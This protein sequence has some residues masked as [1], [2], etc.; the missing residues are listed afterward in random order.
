MVNFEKIKQ[1][2]NKIYPNG[3]DSWCYA[4]LGK[5]IVAITQCPVAFFNAGASGSD[6]ENWTESIPQNSATQGLTHFRFA[7]RK[8]ENGNNVGC[9]YNPSNPTYCDAD[10]FGKFP[11]TPYVPLRN[12]LQTFCSMMGIRA[13]LWHQGETDSER[14]GGSDFV[15]Y[16]TNFNILKNRVQTDFRDENNNPQ[17]GLSWFVSKVSW[18]RSFPDDDDKPIPIWSDQINSNLI[19]QQSILGNNNSIGANTDNI[20][21]Q[22][23]PNNPTDSTRARKRNGFNV[24]FSNYGLRMLAD[25]WL[26]AQPWTGNPISGKPLLPITITAS[27]VNAGNYNLSAPTGYAEYIWV[28]DGK[29]F[30][31]YIAKG[32]TLSDV[33][34]FSNQ[35]IMCYVSKY[36]DLNEQNFFACQPVAIG[37]ETP[38]FYPDFLTFDS[39]ENDFLFTPSPID[40]KAYN[41]INA[42]NAVKNNGTPPDGTKVNYQAGKAIILEN[43]FNVQSGTTFKAEI[44]TFEDSPQTWFSDNIGNGS[45]SSNVTNNVLSINGTGSLGGTSD[46]IHFY[47]SVYSGDVTITARIDAM[48]TSNG[49]RAGIMIRNTNDSDSGFYELIIDGNGNVGKL[50]RKNA[51]ETADIWG[52]AQCPT[53]G[54]WIK[55]EKAGNTITCFFR[56]TDSFNWLE[57]V[58]WDEHSDNN[59]SANF[60]IGFVAYS[61]ASATFSNISISGAVVN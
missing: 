14:H 12:T 19:N 45:G 58:G 26:D 39:P 53:S 46:D 50:K 42:T 34:L 55:I 52:F 29:L 9:I 24:H 2:G 16:G 35:T 31:N 56:P 57:I 11:T 8:D 7:F 3:V 33:K 30:S 22:S 61:G 32:R 36:S 5:D 27:T 59:F 18:W 25:K 15:Y 23:N 38:S 48:S 1:H 41:F 21:M 60:Q 49:Q 10:F 43:G 13:I 51:G 54:S 37:R 4:E 20:R 6:I 44:I 28:I 40:Q 17:T 47:N